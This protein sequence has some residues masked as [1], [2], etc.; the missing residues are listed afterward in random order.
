MANTQQVEDIVKKGGFTHFN[1]VTLPKPITFSFYQEWIKEGLHGEMD[2]LALH[3]PQKAKPENLLPRAK[4]AIVVGFDYHTHPE[5]LENWPFKGVKVA[6]YARGKDYHFW[7]KN[8]LKG[9]T[10]QLQKIFPEDVFLVMSD[11]HPVLERDLAYQAGLGWF[12]KNTCLID[13]KKG[14]YFLLGEIFTSL[15]VNAQATPSPDF[16]GK[17]QR[18]LVSCPTQAFIAPQKI[19]A[20]KCISYWTIESRETPPPELR[21]AVGEWFFGCDI[22]QQVCPWNEKVFGRELNSTTSNTDDV[23]ADL[24]FILSTTNSQLN[25]IFAE[26]PFARTGGRGLKR[27]AIMTAVHYNLKELLPEIVSVGQTY[28]ELNELSQWAQAELK[29]L[30]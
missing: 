1:L 8:K 26:T 17:C 7:L 4:S 21:R 13:K 27:N 30:L 2:Y 11:S 19:D 18:C 16:C 10:D 3:L 15:E 14:S 9:V 6:R 29:V 5:P 24:R 23:A 12:G 28:P 22:C 20:R 25:K